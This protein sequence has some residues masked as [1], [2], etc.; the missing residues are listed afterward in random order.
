MKNP[1]APLGCVVSLLATPVTAA[2]WYAGISGGVSNADVAALKRDYAQ[3]L[4]SSPPPRIE[5]STSSQNGG[6]WKVLAGWKPRQFLALELSYSRYG[7]QRFGFESVNE[8]LFGSP[9]LRRSR[10]TRH[11][12]REVSAWGVDVVGVWPLTPNLA[13]HAGVGAANA[14]IK[15]TSRSRFEN[16]GVFE[17][18]TTDKEKKTAAR[19]SLGGSWA[20]VPDWQLRLNYEYLDKIGSRFSPSTE[21]E[22]GRSAQQTVWLS[23]IK[24]F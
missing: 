18:G 2:D 24:L 4:L 5:S 16:I 13:L 19:L 9:A 11:A 22:T 17:S 1:H 15:L 8:Q 3:E 6:A 7:K 14:E 21:S 20:P 12:E 10:L 23:A